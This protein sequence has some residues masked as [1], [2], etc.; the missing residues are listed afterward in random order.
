M[1]NFRSVFDPLNVFGRITRACEEEEEE[2]EE[3][4]KE[5]R[6]AEEEE[7]EEPFFPLGWFADFGRLSAMFENV[8]LVRRTKFSSLSFY[9][10]FVSCEYQNVLFLTIGGRLSVCLSVRGRRRRLSLGQEKT[11]QEQ[12]SRCRVLLSKITRRSR[13]I[14][15]KITSK[16]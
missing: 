6:L 16:K 1:T 2:E 13:G 5:E 8:K 9:T 12:K 11:E 3:E 7:E 10:R 4:E 15:Q 14:L